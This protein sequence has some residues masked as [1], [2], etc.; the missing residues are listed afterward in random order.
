MPYYTI[1]YGIDPSGKNVANGFSRYI[2]NDLLREKYGY[3]GVVCT[4]WIITGDNPKVETMNGKPWGVEHLT[5]DERHFEAIYA[6]CDQ[7][8]GNDEKQPVIAAYNI[9]CEKFGKE[10][11]DSL[12]LRKWQPLQRRILANMAVLRSSIC[13]TM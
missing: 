10:S 7:F 5:I 6:G 13:S 9:W 12:P 3:D 4:D 1:S 8:G 2:I 11:T